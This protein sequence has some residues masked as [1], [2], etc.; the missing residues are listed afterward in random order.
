MSGQA[1][2]L[3]RG[4]GGFQDTLIYPSNKDFCLASGE[5]SERVARSKKRVCVN[6]KGYDVRIAHISLASQAWFDPKYLTFPCE[7]VQ[8]QSKGGYVEY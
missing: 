1:G 2:P 5:I 3:A 6:Q 7:F 8:A 4:E